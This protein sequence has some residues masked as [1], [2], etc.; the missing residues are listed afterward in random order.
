MVYCDTPFI[1]LGN[2]NTEYK[3]NR[4]I[5]SFFNDTIYSNTILEKDGFVLARAK[6][7]VDNLIICDRNFL[8]LYS[9]SGQ[10]KCIDIIQ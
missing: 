2:I 7:S 10:I 5:L 6:V 3:D 1:Y 9:N 8:G 4:E